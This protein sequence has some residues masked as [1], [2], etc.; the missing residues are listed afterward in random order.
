MFVEYFV[1]NAKIREMP[2]Y[3]NKFVHKHLKTQ[4]RFW[5]K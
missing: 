1:F 4:K 3:N 2:K 5:I